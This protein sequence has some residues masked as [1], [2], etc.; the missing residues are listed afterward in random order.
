ML[1][2]LLFMANIFGIS[3]LAWSQHWGS[4]SEQHR[5]VVRRIKS[6]SLDLDTLSFETEISVLITSR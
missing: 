1:L 4:I 2:L 5:D 3:P 6:E